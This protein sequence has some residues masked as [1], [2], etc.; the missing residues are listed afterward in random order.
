MK[1]MQSEKRVELPLNKKPVI[2]GLAYHSTLAGICSHEFIVNHKIAEFEC[3]QTEG[4]IIHNDCC[5]YQKNGDNVT[6][7]ADMELEKAAFTMQRPLK[8]NQKVVIAFHFLLCSNYKNNILFELTDENG[9]HGNLTYWFW[10]KRNE[11]LIK[12]LRQNEYPVFFSINRDQDKIL[13]SFS[14]DGQT[15][16]VILAVPACGIS[17]EITF[18]MTV[19][20]YENQWL[21]WF[22]SNFLQLESAPH[23]GNVRIHYQYAMVK[24]WSHACSNLF[25][26]FSKESIRKIK[27][28]CPDYTQYF[29]SHLNHDDYIDVDLDEFYLEN[30]MSYQKEHFVH[31]NLIYGYDSEK[32]CFLSAGIDRDGYLHHREF[33]FESLK[34]AIESR[35]SD[36]LDLIRYDPVYADYPLNIDLIRELILEYL[37]EADSLYRFDAW[38][39]RHSKKFFGIGIYDSFINR[40]DVFIK[41]ERIIYF[42]SEHFM[43]MMNRLR[44]LHRRGKISDTGFQNLYQESEKLYNLSRDIIARVLYMKTGRKTDFS[45]FFIEKLNELKNGEKQFLHHLL[46]ELP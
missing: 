25:L 12:N 17:S 4:W 23:G 33:R 45:S 35:S 6:V 30:T 19:S 40:L 3:H 21:N 28:F 36:R 41:D 26:T 10:K 16:D 1:N 27:E 11:W 14:S 34:P 13:L 29:I 38:V 39:P 5:D 32:K 46:S 15:W 8:E 42:I 2:R 7:T 37:N 9:H 31:P 43:L 18:K 22:Y 44:F 24:K 20:V